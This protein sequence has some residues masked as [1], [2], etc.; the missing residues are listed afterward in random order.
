MSSALKVVE[1]IRHVVKVYSGNDFLPLFKL[2]DIIGIVARWSMVLML[3]MRQIQILIL[4]LIL[5]EIILL[6]EMVVVQ[7]LCVEEIAG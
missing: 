3:I 6:L 2:F 5:V 7:R 1:L 4:G